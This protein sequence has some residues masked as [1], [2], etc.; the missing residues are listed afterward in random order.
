MNA[1]AAHGDLLVDPPPAGR[2]ST[3]RTGRCRLV[4]DRLCGLLALIPALSGSS[5]L[6]SSASSCREA[7]G[8]RADLRGLFGAVFGYVATF[9]ESVLVALLI[10]LLAPRY[11]AA[12]AALRGAFKL[13]VYSF[14]PVWLAGIFLLL[15]G[16]RFLSV[17][18]LYGVYLLMERS[19]GG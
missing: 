19:A 7:D 11:S 4:A 17:P 12:S 18:A 13:A 1:I 9:V 16:L 5:A 15:P 10:D 8:A 2:G 6:A 14:T 3:K